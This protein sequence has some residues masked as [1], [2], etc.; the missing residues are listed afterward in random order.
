VL[1]VAVALARGKLPSPVASLGIAAALSGVVLV[2]RSSSGPTPHP[3]GRPRLVLMLAL[4]AAL[5]FGL[6]FVFVAAGSTGGGRSPFWTVAGARGGSLVTLVLIAAA[7]RRRLAWPGRRI[8]ALIAVGVA[9]TGAN[10]LYAYATLH[11]NLG[12]VGVLGSLYPVATVLLARFLLRERLSAGQSAGV[13]LA[14]TGV[15]LLAAG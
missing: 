5:G 10:V 12:V 7:Q 6:F 11:G 1:P 13:V 9:D 15:A 2:S 4:G 3:G 8:A 14:L